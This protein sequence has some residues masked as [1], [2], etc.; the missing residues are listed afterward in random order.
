MDAQR[1]ED[2]FEAYLN[3]HKLGYERNYLVGTELPVEKGNVDFL[4]ESNQGRVFCDV[5]EIRGS[6]KGENPNGEIDAYKLIRRDVKKLREKFGKKRPND[7]CV[8]VTMNFS[9]KYFT[10]WTVARA[11]FGD[12]GITVDK[13]S[14]RL[15]SDIHHLPNGNATMTERHNRS[16]SGILVFGNALFL[17]PN[18]FAYHYIQEGFFPEVCLIQRNRHGSEAESRSLSE[19]IFWPMD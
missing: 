11:M 14:V 4:V 2:I 3:K 15:T 19:I 6:G 10:A 8:L 12:M 17:F 13:R 5:K 18:P 16:I 9:R 1:S 7:P